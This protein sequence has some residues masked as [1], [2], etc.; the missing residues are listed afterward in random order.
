MHRS[1]TMQRQS[2]PG[3]PAQQSNLLENGHATPESSRPNQLQSNL[4]FPQDRQAEIRHTPSALLAALQGSTQH[5]ASNGVHHVMS[6]GGQ[7]GMPNG[8]HHSLAT[9]GQ[10][11]MSNSG[12]QGVPINAHHLMPNG[13]QPGVFT[14]SQHGM[15]SVLNGGQLA[16]QLPHLQHP[17]NP[18]QALFQQHQQQQKQQQ[19]QQLQVP[20]AAQS[21][22]VSS[23]MGRMPPPGFPRP[24]QQNLQDAQHQR[25]SAARA[26]SSPQG[27]NNGMRPSGGGAQPPP[28]PLR[29][30]LQAQPPSN[31]IPVNGPRNIRPHSSPIPLH[32]KPSGQGRAFGGTAPKADMGQLSQALNEVVDQLRPSQEEQQRQKAAFEQVRSTLVHQ[33][34]EAKVHLFGSTANCLSI[35]NNNDIDVCLELPEGIEDQ[36]GKGEIVEQMGQLLEQ[37]GMRDVLPLPKARVPVVKFVVGDTNTKVDITVNNILAIVN[38]KLLKDYGATDERLLQLVFVVK[39]W[40]K[41]RQVNDSYRG[42]LSSYC[43]VLM[44]IHL[45]QQRSP[46]ILPC[47]QAMEPTHIRTVGQWNCDYFD[48][49]E[50]LSGFGSANKEGLAE[51]VWSFFEYWAWR[52]DYNNSVVSVRTGGF[53]TKSHKEWTRRVGN[54]RHLVCIEDP[55]EVSHDLG[56]TVDRQTSGVLHKEFDRAA[57][58]LRDLPQPLDKLMDPY[59]AGKAD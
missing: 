17:Q 28:P 46:P 33:W 44:C 19:Q 36:A 45:L 40:A 24:L 9:A 35:C 20:P 54:E 55:F 58:I 25:A 7:H 31:R 15:G 11:V 13:G 21:P 39:L 49:V 27:L 47:L 29:P 4:A 59:R 34:P 10:H 50:S 2:P 57:C 22:P 56:R 32:A 52:H 8:T 51:L 26:F 14:G 38:T 5:A 1:A 16:A 23:H 30:A 6:G 53:L 18:L 3:F 43:Y 41:R 48:D 37:A 12:H 42:T